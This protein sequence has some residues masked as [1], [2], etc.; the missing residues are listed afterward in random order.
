[1]KIA[2]DAREREVV[3]VIGTTVFLGDDVFDM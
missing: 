1:V 2:V 3:N